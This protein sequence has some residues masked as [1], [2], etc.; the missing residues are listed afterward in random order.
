M[1]NPWSEPD[2]DTSRTSTPRPEYPRPD[3]QRGNTDGID[4]RNLNGRWSFEFDPHDVGEKEA[5]YKGTRPFSGSI[6]VPFPWEAHLA[7]DDGHLASNDN[8]FSKQA[9]L[10]PDDVDA[11]N[12]REQTR[13]EIGWYRTTVTLPNHWYGQRS[14][15]H[16]CA[17]DWQ[18]R[19]WVNGRFMGEH[20]GGY[21]PFEF[22]ITE[23]CCPGERTEIIVRVYDPND[24]RALPG[25]K[26]IDWYAR[27]S[28]IWQT[29]FLEPRPQ[30]FIS[31]IKITPD[32]DDSSA[33][34]AATTTG[35][36]S[37]P[38]CK[39]RTTILSPDGKTIVQ[40]ASCDAET[41]NVSIPDPLL[42]SPDTP[43]LYE[44]SVELLTADTLVD[45]VGTYFGMRKISIAPL[46]GTTT[47]YIF[48]ND[49]PAY[50]LGALNQSFNPW[51]V[52]TF[53]SDEAIQEDL[54]RTRSFGF[55]FLRLH[56]KIEEPRF[57]Y[58]ADRLGVLLMCDIPN[59][60]SDA[61]SE[62]AQARWESTLRTTIERDYNHPSI[63]SWCCFNETWGLGGE[64]FKQKPDR[65]EWVREMYRLA[66]SLD[67]SR[68][69]E[70]N[71]PCL[72]DHIETQINSW[73][74]YINDYGEA[75]HHIQNVVEKTFPGSEFNYTGGNTQSDAP[76]MN[77]EYGG[78]SAGAGDKDI[79]WCFKFLTNE[80]RLH[81]KIC[82]YIYT[83]LQDIEWEHN[84]FMNYD[85]TVKSFGYDYRVINNLD[86]V[87]IDAPPGGT[88]PGGATLETDIYTSHFSSRIV[89][90]ASLFWRI[91]TLDAWGNEKQ[92]IRSGST[93]VSFTQYRVEK[94]HRLILEMPAS[95]QVCTLQIWIEDAA[96]S[97]VAQN[98]ISREVYDAPLPAIDFRKDYLA[99]RYDVA[100]YNVADWIG[101]TQTDGDLVIGLGSGTFEYSIELPD[102]MELGSITAM[103]FWAE[104]SS[105]REDSPQT[106]A[107]ALPSQVNISVNS[108][109]V[110]TITLPDAPADSRGVL[111]YIHGIAGRYGEL[112]RTT[113]TGDDLEKILTGIVENHLTI[114]Y[115]VTSANSC[116][117]GLAVFGARAGRYPVQPCAVLRF[118]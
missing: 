77:S 34:I 50:L 26:Q 37:L 86:T 28:G 53:P 111:S 96:G 72:Y 70:D 32:I 52:Y 19:A 90:G 55:N 84:G 8:W 78:I 118:G 57:L 83:E 117:N 56:I 12:Y 47:N 30:A 46:P 88:I 107:Y 5:W 27:T 76:L 115:D 6:Q 103:E 99:A 64:A 15:L 94:V 2:I 41:F 25:G 23:A 91:D 110:D 39:L 14:I 80:L 97:V 82:G 33:L 75:S 42:W 69:I 104:L 9:F 89:N 116:G 48:L 49:K 74:F 100:S 51:G 79:S 3:F 113:A 61:Y 105:G 18:T 35:T 98:F 16:F 66:R 13:Q 68:L 62:V 73:H 63:F 20:E 59:F 87:L 65:H 10:N 40:D 108:I 43:F 60:A 112:T 92:G 38:G 102:G 101:G 45:R 7:W 11:S 36:E 1:S 4:W 93:P 71:S 44:V 106:D 21:A 114:R 31:N 58:W 109:P 81:E 95:N 22:D 54:K 85:R 29:V 17:V 67:H 24:H